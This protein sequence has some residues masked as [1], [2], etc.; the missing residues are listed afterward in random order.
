RLDVDALRKF[1]R[2]LGEDILKL[3]DRIREACGGIDFNIDSPKQLGDVL[4][5]TLKIGGEKPKRTKTGQY[6]TSEDVL[7][8]LVDA[9]PVVPL[10][11]EYR[12][13]RK[14]K[15]TY[16]DTLPDMVDP[17]TGRVHTS[18]RQAVAAT[19]RLSSESPNLQN[20]P[21]RTEKGREIR[22]AFVPR[23]QDHLLL[24]AD[25]SQ[26][27]LRVIAHMSGDKGL[28]EA[29]SKGLDIHAA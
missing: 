21:I 6:Q 9:H 22:K 14:L 7:S 4:F 11:L 19:G 3:Q 20:I 5:E 8:T 24:S 12:A 28:Q 27:E 18:Y 26:I 15:S 25:Y 23:D 10:V 13:L 1:S 2:E 29:F 17:A 16:V